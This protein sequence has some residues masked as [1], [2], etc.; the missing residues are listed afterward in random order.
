MPAAE[1]ILD[2]DQAPADAPT[3][4]IDDL[5]GTNPYDYYDAWLRPP[6]QSDGDDADDSP[7]LIAQFVEVFSARG[8]SVQLLLET[9]HMHMNE[10]APLQGRCIPRFGGLFRHGPLYCLVFEDGGR[11]ITDIE[12]RDTPIRYVWFSVGRGR[13]GREGG[14]EGGRRRFKGAK[15]RHEH[16]S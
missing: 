15:L 7:G 6:A 9:Y 11:E 12:W 3:I 2:L 14:T 10:L 16:K 1:P 13:G 4:V 5:L 8:R